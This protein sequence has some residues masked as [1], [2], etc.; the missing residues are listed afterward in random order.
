MSNYVDMM[1]CTTR[2]HP[3]LVWESENVHTAFTDINRV[4]LDD[5]YGKV[6]ASIY[7]RKGG[8]GP[9]GR[10]APPGLFGSSWKEVYIKRGNGS[11]AENTAYRYGFL[12]GAGLVL[13]YLSTR[14]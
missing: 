4:A 10:D 9:A 1:K 12:I 13:Y 3:G 5:R 6:G 7:K 14:E 11:S 2:S 8:E